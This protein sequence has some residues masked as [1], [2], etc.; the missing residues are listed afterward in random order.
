MPLLAPIKT[1]NR[2]LYFG[3]RNQEPASFRGFPITAGSFPTESLA[4]GHWPPATGHYSPPCDHR[5]TGKDG[6]LSTTSVNRRG[7][8]SMPRTELGNHC[9]NR[10][11]VKWK[12]GVHAAFKVAKRCIFRRS[13]PPDFP[14]LSCRHPRGSRHMSTK[15]LQRPRTRLKSRE[16]MTTMTTQDSGARSVASV[17]MGNPSL[18]FG[19]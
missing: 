2:M 18:V 5:A 4:T 16:R 13:L 9:L 8:P 17:K 12:R 19:R 6:S 3:L 7:Q 15:H 1:L 14:A 11:P 10:W